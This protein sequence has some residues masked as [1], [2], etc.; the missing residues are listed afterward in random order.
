MTGKVPTAVDFGKFT[1]RKHFNKVVPHSR[2]ICPCIVKSESPCETGKVYWL[3]FLKDVKCEM[4]KTSSQRKARQS[5][6]SSVSQLSVC[7][8]V[9]VGSYKMQQYRSWVV[10]GTKTNISSV[11]AS[12]QIQNKDS[13]FFKALYELAPVCIFDLLHHYSTSKCLCQLLLCS[14][15]IPMLWVSSW[16]VHYI[17]FYYIFRF[18][19]ELC[20]QHLLF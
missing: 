19:V 17:F 18:S 16:L 3:H 4:A 8:Y 13:L 20:C 6:S 11:L 12:L 10:P 2:S 15:H 14:P 9:G 1:L 7:F 5:S